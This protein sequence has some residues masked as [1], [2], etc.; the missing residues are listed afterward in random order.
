MNAAP[1]A[2]PCAAALTAWWRR[3]PDAAEGPWAVAFSG[4]ADSTALLLAA[5]D[6]WP[7]Q[8]VALHVHHGLQAAADGF[9]THARWFCQRLGVPL[10]S[11][12][13]AARHAPGESPEDAARRA[14][15][16]ALARLATG[17]RAVL[18]A[19][20]ADDQVES[21]LLALSRGAGLP[22][23]AGMAEGFE[24]HGTRFARPML[25]VDGEALRA[26]LREAGVPH[27][28]DP[29]NTD[30]RYTR[31]RI[32]RVLLPAWR[33]QF[34]SCRDTVART[35]RHAAQAQRLLAE[36]AEQDLTA[37]GRPPHIATLRALSGDRQANALRLWLREQGQAGASE[38]QL[39]ALLRQVAACA[40]RGHQIRLKVAGGHVLRD[41][42]Q[43]R[44]Q[45]PG[46]G[47]G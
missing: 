35:A 42:A 21:V 6:L 26:W 3:Q 28:L 17:C 7:G 43:L 19:Q 14:R 22:G 34:P 36:L 40:T 41:G 47:A 44:F 30:L 12:R 24:R 4:G 18:L 1:P 5:H 16:Q 10:R 15:Y 23:L 2:N 25:G 9:E 8:V 27:V 39:A 45:P 32:R 38:A 20:H 31:N 37:V 13:V 29:S 33:E 11:E 46:P